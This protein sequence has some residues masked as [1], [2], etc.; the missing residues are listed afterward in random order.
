MRKSSKV[1]WIALVVAAMLVVAALGALATVESTAVIYA[2]NVNA[3]GESFDVVYKFKDNNTDVECG[4]LT[5]TWDSTKMTATGITAGTALEGADFESKIEAGKATI[6]W[7]GSSID[8]ATEAGELFTVSF[9]D[10]AIDLAAIDLAVDNFG[11]ANAFTA[12]ELAADVT[13]NKVYASAGTSFVW[14]EE[15][16]ATT[17][18]EDFLAAAIAAAEAGEGVDI[19][20]ELQTTMLFDENV[21]AIGTPGANHV[22]SVNVFSALDSDGAATAGIEI[23]S[24]V[25]V[26]F[27]GVFNF[28]N[29]TYDNVKIEDSA[30]N[31]SSGACLQFVEGMGTFGHEETTAGS[32]DW[33]LINTDGGSYDPALAGHVT[34][35]TGKYKVIC[36]NY[37]RGRFDI[38]I[39]NAYLFVGGDVYSDYIF[40]GSHNDA[41]NITTGSST[42][43]IA[44]N[45]ESYYAAGGSWYS[46]YPQEGAVT[47]VKDNAK[48]SYISAGTTGTYKT[49]EGAKFVLNI[50]GGDFTKIGSHGFNA[51]EGTAQ[52]NTEITVTG[53]TFDYLYGGFFSQYD[54]TNQTGSKPYATTMHCNISGTVKLTLKNVNVSGY[55]YG[56]SQMWAAHSV[57]DL[58]TTI[59]LDG[60]VV[61]DGYSF[62]GGSDVASKSITYKNTKLATDAEGYATTVVNDGCIHK[63]TTDITF[64]NGTQFG[65]TNKASSVNAGSKLESTNGEH[66]VTT[67]FNAYIDEGS[68]ATFSFYPAGGFYLG[69]RLRGTSNVHS[70]DTVAVIDSPKLAIQTGSWAAIAGGSSLGGTNC[71]HSGDIDLYVKNA[72]GSFARAILGSSYIEG[73]NGNHSGDTKVA[74]ENVTMTHTTTITLYGGSML[75]STSAE[76]S[77]NSHAIINKSGSFASN[78]Y[79]GSFYNKANIKTGHTGDSKLT[80]NG[81]NMKSDGTAATYI[82]VRNHLFGGSYIQNTNNKMTGN[83]T[84]EL[85]NLFM[86]DKD[87]YNFWLAKADGTQSFGLYGGSYLPGYAGG[88]APTST[89]AGT[90]GAF[91]ETEMS[92][93][94][95]IIARSCLFVKSP[96]VV[97]EKTYNIAN[98]IYGGCYIDGHGVMSGDSKVVLDGWT[99]IDEAGNITEKAGV[100]KTAAEVYGGSNVNGW[101]SIYTDTAGARNVVS[102][103]AN[104]GANCTGASEVIIY[105][106]AGG[107][108]NA[109]TRVYKKTTIGTTVLGGS[110]YSSNLSGDKQQVKDST[111]T[112]NGTVNYGG[113][114]FGGSKYTNIPN[115]TIVLEKYPTTKVVVESSSTYNNTKYGGALFNRTGTAT[116]YAN[117]GI[118]FKGK[119]GGKFYAGSSTNGATILAETHGD[120]FIELYGS[121][122][123]YGYS[124]QNLTLETH[125]YN[126]TRVTQKSGK[127]VLKFVGG[128][129]SNFSKVNGISAEFDVLDLYRFDG[130]VSTITDRY[131]ALSA[132]VPAT[133]FNPFV[134]GVTVTLSNKNIANGTKFADFMKGQTVTIGADTYAYD[135]LTAFDVY[136]EADN[137]FDFYTYQFGSEQKI[138]TLDVINKVKV[139]EGADRSAEITLTNTSRDTG[140]HGHVGG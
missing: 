75:S 25:V 107:S 57:S 131:T 73:T 68:S 98:P 129:P 70:G 139:G 2:D 47:T 39:A 32:G 122:N 77:G 10:V 8:E 34:A 24:T 112:L 128:I 110:A 123:L 108:D 69:T 84:L 101:Y 117:S 76:H 41:N 11:Y 33:G 20:V 7:V 54:V 60:V 65:S 138:D 114:V 121:A 1:L 86:L 132:T 105:G 12:Y 103:G 96:V 124:S 14:T 115:G 74:V 95:E 36:G 31:W 81:A 55:I 137:A 48:V 62:Y 119:T 97:G 93:N 29:I 66:A 46:N 56:G 51:M 38:D 53:G 50:E 64:K 140:I 23:K 91:W 18:P 89:K 3:N 43:I 92:G 133:V 22:G 26:N 63:G 104:T 17:E 59:V 94:S 116:V 58:N 127:N 52:V 126:T 15:I 118:I 99:K 16:A 49:K 27:Y 67:T 130:T 78:V 135:E 40:G 134:D 87:H 82:Q 85:N 5:L 72:V 28:N 111:V 35:Y 102:A 71:E 79:G 61:A 21:E 113:L 4:K 88:S 6:A 83:S 90:V 13:A 45:A 136:T 30:Q 19:N 37:D 125:A 100:I 109:E 120:M 106:L 44:D 42:V 80:V 9:D